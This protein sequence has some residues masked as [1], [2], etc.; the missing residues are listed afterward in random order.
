MVATPPSLLLLLSRSLL[1][2]SPQG[3]AQLTLAYAQ[4]MRGP[5]TRMMGHA[6]VFEKVMLA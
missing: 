5:L 1:S 2:T 3:P 4:I 6:G